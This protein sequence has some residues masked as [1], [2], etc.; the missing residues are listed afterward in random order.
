METDMA[1]IG[2]V[3]RKLYRQDDLSGLFAACLHSAFASAGPWL[4]TVLALGVIAAV[5]QHT[6]GAEAMF[7][8]RVILIYNFSF[9][10]VIAGPVFL[11]ATRFLA[12]AIY[13]R[14][15]SGAPGMLVGALSLLWG[16]ELLIAVPFYFFYAVLPPLVSL[17]AVINFL[18]LSAVWLISIFISALKN[19]ALITR[20]F[21]LGMALAAAGT[22]LLAKGYGTAGMLAGFSLGLALIAAL[23]T[24]IVLAEYPYPVKQPF[25]FLPYFRRYWEI[26]VSG[27]VIG[28]AAWVDKWIMWFAPEATRMASGLLV[29][30]DYDS[31]MFMAYLTT[32]PAM[33]M[34]LFSTETQFFEHYSRFYRDIERKATLAKIEQNHRAVSRSIFGSAGSFFLLQGSIAFLGILV[35]PE[36]ITTLKGN[37][38]QI[39]MLR[40]GL[41]GALFH[42][43]TLFLLI[44]LSY[45]DSRK[46]NLAIQ[47]VFLLSN[48][49]LTWGSLQAGFSYYGYGYFLSAF[50]TF[51]L[52]AL[53]VTRYVAQ[54]PYHTFITTNASVR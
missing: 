12:D 28:M 24:G 2:F 43:L 41:L 27:L 51:V 33:A 54:L 8:F 22:L 49:V 19:Y 36:V 46:L 7:D 10:L 39:G 47:L 30:P 17:A 26:A 25:A 48:A 23:L 21:L 15:V 44:L 4:F 3:L 34:F 5:G 53:A 32:V 50:L 52:A 20:A 14:D 40:Y 9:S 11:I 37:Y 45:F 6:V 38:M 31:A 16:V 13:K 18:L 1:G 29:Y 42:V 35:A